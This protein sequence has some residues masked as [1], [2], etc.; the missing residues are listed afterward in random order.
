LGWLEKARAERSTA[1]PFLGTNPRF[2]AIRRDP[3]FK[4]IV[5]SVGLEAR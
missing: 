3:R 1:I 5:R 2:A 4:K